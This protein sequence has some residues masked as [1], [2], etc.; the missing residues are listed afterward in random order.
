MR[1][2]IDELQASFDE[3]IRRSVEM[4]KAVPAGDLF[5]KPEK[6]EGS[7]E[8]FSF[9]EFMLRSAGASPTLVGQRASRLSP[10]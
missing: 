10:V 1:D 8:M 7:Y 6:F 3:L 2:I 9:G 5:R 4:T